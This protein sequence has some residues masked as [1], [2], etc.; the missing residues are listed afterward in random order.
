VAGI[1]PKRP[2]TTNELRLSTTDPEVEPMASRPGRFMVKFK[3][4][5]VD[6]LELETLISPRL[7]AV[8]VG[9]ISRFGLTISLY[10]V[11]PGREAEI[12]TVVQ[13][14]IDDVNRAR[15]EARV[16]AAHDR[17]V[18]E[19]AAAASEVELRT[20]TETFQAARRSS[21]RRSGALGAQIGG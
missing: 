9:A 2:A 4:E 15:G 10:G 19:E 5:G 6:L 8:G 21:T 1:S 16:R 11:Q 7:A 3:L 13:G 20:V 17:S 12:H 14:A 18:S